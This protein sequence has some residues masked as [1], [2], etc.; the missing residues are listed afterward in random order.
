MSNRLNM[1]VGCG[2]TVAPESFRSEVISLKDRLSA[3]FSILE[4]LGLVNGTNVDV[5]HHD[6][7]CVADADLFVAVCDFPSTGLGVEI[8]RAR[9]LGTPTLAVSCFDSKV[10]R[11][12]LGMAEYEPRMIFAE[13]GNMALDVPR[14]VNVHLLPQIQ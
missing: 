8:E 4:F 6:M 14:L 5:Y 10:T 9:Q 3:D 7:K 11:L 2:L 1:Y 12:V 13:Y